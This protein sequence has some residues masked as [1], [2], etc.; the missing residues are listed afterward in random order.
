M[1][2]FPAPDARLTPT[3]LLLVYDDALRTDAELAG[4]TKTARLGPLR[5]ATF[6]T[7]QGFVSYR[8]LPADPAEIARLVDAAIAHFS[9]DH[10]VEEVEWKTRLHDDAPGLDDALRTRGFVPEDAESVMLGPVE[11]L[12]GAEPPAGVVIRPVTEPDDLL[13]ALHMADEVFASTYAERMATELCHRTASGDPVRQWVAEI[14]GRI[15][16]TGRIDP[17][18]GTPVAGVWGGATL[19]EFRG[20]GI[21]R[22]LTSARVR[23]VLPL[24]VR[25]IH[26]DSTPASR[27]ILERAGLVHITDTRPWIRAL[28]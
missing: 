24:G 16:S 21:Y 13:A 6:G 9:A 14:D 1:P 8:A 7:S 17:V 26:S 25:F 20:R 19:P 11:G 15:V 23:S 4:A 18:P 2:A 10:R 28:G 3:E 27:P 12:I 22:A 5:L